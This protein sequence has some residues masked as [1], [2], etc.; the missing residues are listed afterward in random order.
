MWCLEPQTAHAVAHDLVDYPGAPRAS[1]AK[2]PRAATALIAQACA[3][4][5]EGVAIAP[6]VARLDQA[7][8]AGF[9]EYVPT[10]AACARM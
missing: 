5:S 6:P 4:C 1:R 3:P 10:C 9:I 2:Q 7:L 8:T